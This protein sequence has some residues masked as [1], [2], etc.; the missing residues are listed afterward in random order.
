VTRY[1]LAQARF[2]ADALTSLLRPSCERVEVAG[3]VRRE[4]ANVGDIELL[5]IPRVERIAADLLGTTHHTHDHLDQQLQQLIAQHVLDYRLNALGS[6]TYGPQNKLL[7]HVASGIPLDIFST[8]PLFYGMSLV[9][10]TGPKEFNI[11]LMQRF[12]RLG[13]RGHAYG[14]VT[15]KGEELPCPTEDSVFRLAEWPYV[16]PRLRDE[17][18]ARR[19]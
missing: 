8:T 9:V 4:R 5:C 12:Q 7:L 2:I 11:A 3:S 13:M 1:P 19:R 14:G 10:R 16:P 18:T 15:W 17:W 6:R